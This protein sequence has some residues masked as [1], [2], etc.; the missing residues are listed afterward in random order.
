L[1][2]ANANPSTL[3]NWGE[4]SWITMHQIGNKREHNNYWYLTEIFNAKNPKPALNGE[5]YYAGYKDARGAEIGVHYW[6]GADGNTEKDNEIVRSG[7]YGSF[8]SGGLAGH[9]YGAEGIWGGDIEDE[10]PTHMWDAFT[11][12]S[13]AQMKHL[14]TFAFSVGKQYQDLVPLADLVSPNKSHDILSYEGWA[15]CARTPDKKNYLIYFERGCPRAEVRGAI[16][17]SVYNA[18]WFDPRNG[19]WSDANSGKVAANKIGTIVLP[20]F[21][22]DGDWGLKLVYIGPN[23]PANPI[24]ELRVEESQWP[25]R[26]KKYR[27]HLK[28]LGGVGVMALVVVGLWRLRRRNSR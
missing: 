22:G 4:E 3:E 18:Q 24:A 20:E 5:P 12:E 27:N 9:V 14:K 1:L 13:G 8:L 28:V 17:N 16:L 6:R 23:D 11:W 7:A 26:Y 2:S 15:Y 10:A 21:P 19:T 25:R